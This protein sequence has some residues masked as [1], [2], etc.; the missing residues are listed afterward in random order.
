MTDFNLADMNDT[1]AFRFLHCI[2][3]QRKRDVLADAISAL[4]RK[5]PN[6]RAIAAAV[7]G[8]YGSEARGAVP[9]LRQLLGDADPLVRKESVIALGKIGV[10]AAESLSDLRAA[11]VDE[12]EVVR[13]S[14][15]EAVQSII[16]KVATARSD[17][18]MLGSVEDLI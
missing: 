6:A 18:K 7:V 4:N 17:L 12:F 15:N 13:M 8:T 2:S 10:A 9:Q 14:A 3:I 11:Q 16:Q 1:D 5:H